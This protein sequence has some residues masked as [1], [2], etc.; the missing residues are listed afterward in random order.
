MN[1]ASINSEEAIVARAL[2][3]LDPTTA[4]ITMYFLKGTS[5]SD[6][7]KRLGFGSASEVK[8]LHESGL[9]ALRRPYTTV[10]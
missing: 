3:R 4:K 2:S 8:E 7:A 10:A 1:S 6:I 5:Y 9:R